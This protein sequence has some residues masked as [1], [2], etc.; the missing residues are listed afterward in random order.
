MSQIV[1]R[2]FRS[3][4][5]IYHNMP[6]WGVGSK[7]YQV[8]DTVPPVD[9]RLNYSIQVEPDRWMN[10]DGSVIQVIDDRPEHAYRVAL[11]DRRLR[12]TDAI[13]GPP[14]APNGDP[15]LEQVR[16]ELFKLRDLY[17]T[18]SPSYRH[19]QDLLTYLEES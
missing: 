15:R 9:G 1:Y 10:V 6:E 11:E 19:Y 17:P 13:C 18:G 2:T 7:V 14:D 8:G 5:G 16:L 4:D 12:F 3:L